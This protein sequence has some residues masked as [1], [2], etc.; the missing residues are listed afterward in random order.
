MN[1][2]SPP[3]PPEFYGG[4]H[5]QPS[6]PKRELNLQGPRPSPLKVSKDSHK[7]RKPPPV[8]RPTHTHAHTT[9]TSFP[10][11]S[12]QI[13]HEP[14]IIY[15]VS[16]KVIHATVTDFMSIVQRLTGAASPSSSFSGAGDLSPAARLA[17]I[18]RTSPS[19]RERERERERGS[20]EALMEKELEEFEMGQF[21]GILSPAPASLPP[22]IPPGLFSPGW[23][24]QSLSFLQDLSPH[25]NNNNNFMVSP[26]VSPSPSSLDIF[27][28][29]DFS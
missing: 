14:V 29:F 24:P 8:P 16:P 11:S 13:R 6:P 5:G 19:E 28:L 10:S 4:A 21:P 9:T 1:P 20:G 25:W 7:I 23:D 15:T 3:P 12:D 2:P 26:L 18:E 22:A 27:N 17:S